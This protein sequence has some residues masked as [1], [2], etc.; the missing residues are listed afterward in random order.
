VKIFFDHF[1][2]VQKLN[3]RKSVLFAD[4]SNDGIQNTV[5]EN[6]TTMDPVEVLEERDEVAEEIESQSMSILTSSPCCVAV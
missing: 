6:E 4:V 3:K 5:T 2:P 1:V